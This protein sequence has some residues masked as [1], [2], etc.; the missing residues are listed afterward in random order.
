MFIG[1]ESLFEILA[2]RQIKRGPDFPTLQKTFLRWVVCGIYKA[3][4]PTE[5]V[6]S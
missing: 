2:V 4:S 3:S 5:V 6:K 1:A